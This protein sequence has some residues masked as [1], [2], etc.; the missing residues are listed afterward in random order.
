MRME[1]VRPAPLST[2]ASKKCRDR[3][4]SGRVVGALRLSLWPVDHLLSTP[5]PVPTGVPPYSIRGCASRPC[6]A[7]FSPP[8]GHPGFL[9]GCTALLPALL[10]P[11]LPMQVQ[12]LPESLWL[13]RPSRSQVTDP[14][15][16]TALAGVVGR[17]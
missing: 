8:A 16:R 6:R 12:P 9:Q 13:C 7:I 11:E 15:E 17:Q 2:G 1:P 14:L 10:S 3:G 5:P 4:W